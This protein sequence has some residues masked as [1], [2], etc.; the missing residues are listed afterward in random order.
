MSC[1]PELVVNPFAFFLPFANNAACCLH[2]RKPEKEISDGVPTVFRYPDAFR[3]RC[4]Q[5]LDRALLSVPGYESWRLFDPG[6]DHPVDAD[7]LHAA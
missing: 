1:K 2:R 6:R 3:N 5:A 4:A 7:A